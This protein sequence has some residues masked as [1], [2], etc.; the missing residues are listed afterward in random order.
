LHYGQEIFEGLKAYRADDGDVFLFRPELNAERFGRSAERLAMPV[1]P[2]SLFLDSVFALAKADESWIPEGLGGA[3]YLRPFMFA[4]EPFLGLRPANEYLFATIAMAVR[5]LFE[6]SPP[7]LTLWIARQ[8]RAAPGGTGAAK[9][10]GNY[11]GGLL[12]HV[13]AAKHKCDQV[14]FLDAVE[15]RWVEELGGMNLFFVFADGSV[16]TPPLSDSILAG[17]TRAS[18][19]TLIRDSGAPMREERYSLDQWREDA[20]TGRLREVFACG[21]A[22]G[23]APVGRLLGPNFE[24]T[25]GDGKPGALTIALRDRLTALQRG[26][27]AD[28]YG[29][30]QSVKSNMPLVEPAVT[31]T[32]Q[33]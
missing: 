18:L 13:E 19:L 2:H 14:V 23:V 26:Q 30:V 9:C 3:L 12:A 27:S 28:P 10:G 7:A 11:A 22:A 15:H 33:G 21:T 31:S 25:I 29:W 4:V 24:L 1:L 16:V 20:R 32:F 6:A 8:S 17:V 5:S